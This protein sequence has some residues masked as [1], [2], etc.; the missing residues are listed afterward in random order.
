MN[1][2]NRLVMLLIALL[3][4]AVPVLLILVIWAIVPAD[5]LNQYTGYRSAV[6]A[7]GNLSSSTFTTGVRA[8]VA[9]AGALVAL[10]ALLLLLREL[11]FGRRV[12][13]STTLDETPGRET[14]ITASAVKTLAESAAREV[15]A[16]SPSASLASDDR[17]Y[18][19]SCGI[20]A[21]SSGN[22]TELATRARSN[23]HRVLEEQNVPVQDVEVTVRGSAF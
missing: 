6:E 22:Y 12:A 23:I 8:V 9:I 21:P 18:R 13:R 3:L 5:V 19:V 2:L 11:T 10:L 4:I 1:A 15:G 17:S 7:I 14:R 20:E 16:V